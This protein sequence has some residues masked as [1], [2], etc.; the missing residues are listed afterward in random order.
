MRHQGAKALF[1]CGLLLAGSSA[2]AQAPLPNPAAPEG[3]APPAQPSPAPA[4]A[5]PIAAAEPASAPPPAP[6]AEAAKTEPPP[7]KFEDLEGKFEATLDEESYLR[8]Q[9]QI[10]ELRAAL[11]AALAKLP[12]EY[13]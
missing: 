1:L 9:L 2:V 13:Q 6:P 12:P 7:L 8:K 5:A 10:A 4:P 3:V 11:E